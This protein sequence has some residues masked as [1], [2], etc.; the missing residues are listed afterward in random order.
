MG[1]QKKILI[2]GSSGLVGRV[3]GRSLSDSHDIRGLDIKSAEEEAWDT[4]VAD[5]TDLDAVLPA[6]NGVDT[7]IDLSARPAMDEPWEIV[8]G[9]NITSTYNALEA[10]RLSG[11]KRLVFAS[12]NHATGMYENDHPYS[13]IVAGDYKAL[14]PESI[15]LITTDMPVR[16]DSN[17][18]IAKAF[19]ENAGRYYSDN[20]GLSVICLRIGTLNAP[21]RPLVPRQ[22]ATLLSH[23]DLVQLVSRCINA[24]DTVRFA[25]FYGVSDN[26]WR[27]WDIS[28]SERLVGYRPQ[29]DAEIWRKEG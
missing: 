17:Y 20:F 4:F 27:F 22:F 26:K 8:H 28:N 16:P 9:N 13:A 23:R 25:I 5:T 2:T 6:Y 18:G 7:V 19:G 24:D 11:A 10:A 3:I 21:G 15:P 29:D 14:D 1:Y 12:S